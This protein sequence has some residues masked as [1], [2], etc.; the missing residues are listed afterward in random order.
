M[1]RCPQK[2]GSAESL[3][4]RG[5]ELARAGDHATALECHKL[6]TSQPGADQFS[7]Y[8][9][10]TS[11]IALE[12]NGAA[13]ASFD[14]TFVK[15]LTLQRGAAPTAMPHGESKAAAA[16]VPSPWSGASAAPP[17]TVESLASKRDGYLGAGRISRNSEARAAAPARAG[18]LGRSLTAARAQPAAPPRQERR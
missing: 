14:V 5:W 2:T 4:K 8:H 16:G 7:W 11:E 17:T 15:S 12:M 18:D 13:K 1:P 3:G 10:G 9:R 6:A